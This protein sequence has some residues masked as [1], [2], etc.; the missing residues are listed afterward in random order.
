DPHGS[1]NATAGIVPVKT[2]CIPRA[3]WQPALDAIAVTFL[4]TPMIGAGTVMP[5]PVPQENGFTWEWVTRNPGA[6]GWSNLAPA[7]AVPTATL[8]SPQRIEEGW[9]R[10]IRDNG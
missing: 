7:S 1:V 4:T 2:I 10:L 3:Q 8:A 6:T 9:L 5:V